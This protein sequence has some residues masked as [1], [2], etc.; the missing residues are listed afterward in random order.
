M[1]AF[2]IPFKPKR[3]STNWELD[4]IY[5]HNTL[6]SILHQTNDDYHV[7]VITHD[8]PE[9]LIDSPKVDYLKLPFEYCDFEK[10]EDRNAALKDSGYLNAR[11]VEYLFDQGRKQMYGA[12]IAKV[13]CYEYIM[14]LDADDLVS[15]N[16]VEYISRH[17]KENQVGWYVNKGYYF[18]AEEKIYVRQ[19]Y[20]MNMIS[21]STH[22]V[23]RDILPATD[24]TALLLGANNFFS[25]HGSLP[26]R[27]KKEFGKEL[28]PLPFYAIIYTITN[29]NWSITVDKLK[30]KS[31]Y[32]KVKFLVRRVVFNKPIGQRFYLNKA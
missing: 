2:I 4:S 8:M 20:S 25:S 29:L 22:I 14:C 16:L 21:G 23:H 13:K 31:L 1:L 26:A 6:Q 17:K 5:L 3:N 19:P 12:Q 24:M 28:R 15:K 7:L 10:I 32:S 9:K 27:I 18:L 11:D 30:G